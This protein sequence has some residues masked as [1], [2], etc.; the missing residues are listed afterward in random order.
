MRAWLSATPAESRKVKVKRDAK[1]GVPIKACWL[2]ERGSSTQPK[3][4]RRLPISARLAFYLN[5]EH[6]VLVFCGVT[7]M[8]WR[9][10][11]PQIY[12]RLVS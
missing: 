3:R 9:T 1:K 12:S 7:V 10:V 8:K 4:S 5:H 6:L 2:D 11:H